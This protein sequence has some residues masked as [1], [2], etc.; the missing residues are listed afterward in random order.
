MIELLHGAQTMFEANRYHFHAPS[1]RRDDRA[2]SRG[3]EIGEKRKRSGAE[4]P[5]PDFDGGARGMGDIVHDSA[6]A[7][8]DEPD[9]P[10]S[11]TTTSSL[12]IERGCGLC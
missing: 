10:R 11:K 8:G 6:A 5:S 2:A 1:R 4:S 7:Q 3:A 12:L 9:A